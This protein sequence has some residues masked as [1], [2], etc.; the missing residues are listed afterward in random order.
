MIDG[1][2]GYGFLRF[3]FVRRVSMRLR[4]VWV[5]GLS[6][7]LAATV[8]GCGGSQETSST[9]ATPAAPAGAP[10]GMKVDTATAGTLTG[11]VVLDGTAPKNLPIKMNADPVCVKE[12]S[13]AQLQETYVVGG[14][15]KS[16]GNVF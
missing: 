3:N 9:S 11:T 5:Y 8:M 14:D 1:P 2:P 10:A 6:L 12:T 16:L 7:A 15:G 4:N 13:G